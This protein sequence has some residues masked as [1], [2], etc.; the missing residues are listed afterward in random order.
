MLGHQ[1]GAVVQLEDALGPGKKLYKGGL[2]FFLLK[3]NN[4]FRIFLNLF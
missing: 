2:N 4:Y 1:Q 3:T